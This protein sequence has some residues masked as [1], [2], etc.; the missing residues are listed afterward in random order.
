MA[1]RRAG[2]V[3]GL[4]VLAAVVILAGVGYALVH[5]WAAVSAELARIPAGT[6]GL[7]L[8]VA[9]VS[10]VLTLFGWRML[11]T[12][13][14]SALPLPPSASIFFVGQLGKY[15]PGSVWSVVAQAE[16]GRRLGVPRSRMG[17]VGLLSMGL[18]VVTSALVGVPALPLLFDRGGEQIS[19]WWVA[20]AFLAG[21]LL[22]WPRLLNW[23][24]A[25]GL[26]LLRR[27]PLEHPLS[28]RAIAV[29]SSWF[30]VAWL[31]AGAS[32]LLLARELTP[33]GAPADRLLLA[34]VA[35]YALAAAF[36]MFSVIAPA[37]V[38]VRDG[39][40]ALLLSAVMPLAAATA[41]V[42][43]NRFL[44]VL[45]DVIV[46]ALGYLWGRSHHLLGGGHEP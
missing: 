39:V 7:A 33:L 35:G 3:A 22:L 29:T 43:V 37:G 15:I 11:L 17:V 32:V 4:R 19:P 21:C 1:A 2:L 23:C 13:L 34:S 20:P 24:I 26:R 42:V 18:A 16:M 30:V 46:A 10:P 28:G 5:N 36:G 9:V 40:L 38:G 14:G 12:D 6:V 31:A 41:V 8:F 45:A 27:E 25:T 44:T